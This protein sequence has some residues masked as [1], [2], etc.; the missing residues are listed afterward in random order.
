MT[1]E[2]PISEVTFNLTHIPSSLSKRSACWPSHMKIAVITFFF[3]T[4]EKKK[5]VHVCKDITDQRGESMFLHAY[6]SN[7]TNKD[8]CN[9]H[10]RD[11]HDYYI[12]DPFISF[13][14][15][16][17]HQCHWKVQKKLIVTPTFLKLLS[18]FLSFFFFFALMIEDDMVFY[19]NVINLLVCMSLR[20]QIGNKKTNKKNLSVQQL[21]T[22]FGVNCIFRL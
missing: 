2:K 20:P 6:I 19:S 18:F 3:K 8:Q 13:S 22:T 7:D 21:A 14:I 1:R 11:S 10:K 5:I 12:A 15:F 9:N 17:F 4:K 16:V